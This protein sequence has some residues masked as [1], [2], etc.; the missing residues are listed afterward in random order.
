MA[1]RAKTVADNK[2][3]AAKR[4]K[5]RKP[6]KKTADAVA[7]NKEA[8]QAKDRARVEANLAPAKK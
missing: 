1:D 7:A 2:A 4:F 3:A 8:R 5:D 6:K